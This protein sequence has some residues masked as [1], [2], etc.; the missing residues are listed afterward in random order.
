[1]TGPQVGGNTAVVTVVASESDESVRCA[2]N[3]E[4]FFRAILT[5][6]MFLCDS[7]HGLLSFDSPSLSPSLSS[8]GQSST[9]DCSVWRVTTLVFSA[10]TGA[11]NR[12]RNNEKR[13]RALLNTPTVREASKQQTLEKERASH[14]QPLHTAFRLLFRPFAHIL[15]LK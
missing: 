10:P 8:T 14:N 1:M 12:L 9:L 15:Y 13:S 11:T 4:T 2:Q 3:D 7:V 6:G 5:L